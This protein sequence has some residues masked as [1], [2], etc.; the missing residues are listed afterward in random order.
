MRTTRRYFLAL[1]LFLSWITRLGRVVRAGCVCIRG[2]KSARGTSAG[3]IRREA[4]HGGVAAGQN[5]AC[6]A[7]SPTALLVVGLAGATATE[8]DLVPHV[9]G[10]VLHNLDERLRSS[11][12]GGAGPSGRGLGTHPAPPRG[13]GAPPRPPPAMP[14]PAAI[15][16]FISWP[17]RAVLALAG[18]WCWPTRPLPV[19]AAQGGCGSGARARA[20][21]T[22]WRRPCP[23]SAAPAQTGCPLAPAH[24]Q[25]PAC[26]WSTRASCA[27][28]VCIFPRAFFTHAARRLT[29]QATQQRWARQDAARRTM[30][31]CVAVKLK[32]SLPRPKR[33]AQARPAGS[34]FILYKPK[35]AH[36]EDSSV[37]S[38]L[39]TLSFL[40]NPILHDSGALLLPLSCLLPPVS[41]KQ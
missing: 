1:Y 17:E 10:L 25:H 23:W 35:I 39:V 40:S 41:T 13:W 36:M 26:V 29:Q 24:G 15:S 34:C 28:G 5:R 21:P 14:S 2:P 32:V 4:R 37:M 18:G 38:I 22:G 30:I 8:L 19:L 31:G 33:K 11:K 27:P 3:S 6:S 20:I 7:H 12:G 16:L 9:V